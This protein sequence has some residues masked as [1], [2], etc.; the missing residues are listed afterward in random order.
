VDVSFD[1]NPSIA[2]ARLGKSVDELQTLTHR[3]VLPEFLGIAQAGGGDGA[4]L[5]GDRRV[6]RQLAVLIFGQRW[7]DA[8]RPLLGTL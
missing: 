4:T 3:G 8:V 7:A 2:A 6:V 5:E 1:A